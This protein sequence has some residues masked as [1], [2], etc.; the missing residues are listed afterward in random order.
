MILCDEQVIVKWIYQ[1]WNEC[2]NLVGNLE[3]RIRVWHELE[4]LIIFLVIPTLIILWRRRWFRSRNSFQS[5]YSLTTGSSDLVSYRYAFNH[6]ILSVWRNSW[7]CV[8]SG[9]DSNWRIFFRILRASSRHRSRSSLVNWLLIMNL[10]SSTFNRRGKN[11]LETYRM[12]F[13]SSLYWPKWVWRRVSPSL[14]EFL[15]TSS[16]HSSEGS[17]H[18]LVYISTNCTVASNGTCGGSSQVIVLMSQKK[19]DHMSK[20]TCH[21]EKCILSPFFHSSDLCQIHARNSSD[22]LVYI[23]QDGHSWRVGYSWRV[24]S[25]WV[26]YSC[27][28]GSYI[29]WFS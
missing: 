9:L 22:G 13:K 7:F 29:I 24:G 12:R 2:K 10:I 25:N 19:S 6:F 17:S 23:S 16:K 27:R 1:G 20:A 4:L 3:I 5:I 26:G 28:M 21:R 14:I 18:M 11:N 8:K 15:T